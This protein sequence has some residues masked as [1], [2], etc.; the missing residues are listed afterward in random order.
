MM[1]DWVKYIE[2]MIKPFTLKHIIYL[3]LVTAVTTYITEYILRIRLIKW[4]YV[5]TLVVIIATLYNQGD[6]KDAVFDAFKFVT[7]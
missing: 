4:I 3:I 7:I 6:D 5:G 1:S 2:N